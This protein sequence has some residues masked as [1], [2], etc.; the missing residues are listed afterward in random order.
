MFTVLTGVIIEIRKDLPELQEL[1]VQVDGEASRQLAYNYPDLYRRLAVGDRVCLNAAAVKLGLGTGGRHFVLPDYLNVAA[2]EPA[3]HIMKLRYTP[4]QF[5]IQ[6]AEEEGSPYHTALREADSLAGIPVVAAPLHSM[7]PGV[8]LGF[9]QALSYEPKVAYVMTDG[10][11]LPMALS[12]LVREL[13]GRKWL[14]LT[15]TAGQAFGGDLEAVSLPAA[16]LAARAA[17][18]ADLIVVAMGP[19][20]VGT[21]TKYG[22]SGI[23]QS[24]ILDMTARLGGVPVAVPR[25]SEADPRERHQ[26]L[27]HHSRTILEL[28]STQAW[29]GLSAFLPE[30]LRTQI[31]H[32][33]REAEGV[34][35]HRWVVTEEPEV[36]PLFAAHNL[37]VKSMGRSVE[38]DPAFFQS[39]VAAGYLAAKAREGTMASLQP[40]R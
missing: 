34:S 18:N 5:P 23:E 33:L 4:W 29:L 2:T 3:G 30:T 15:I 37:R 25:M 20:I 39:T 13:K 22:F 21:G 7:L 9:R 17:I 16:L 10:A 27:S 31:A 24:W 19:G 12:D 38:A 8:I 36:A 14:D 6:A 1:A 28:T 11:A 40:W 35:R 32:Q 26:G